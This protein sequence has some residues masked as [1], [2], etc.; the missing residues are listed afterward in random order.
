MDIAG[1]G[2]WAR[3]HGERMWMRG[4]EPRGGAGGGRARGG[5]EADRSSESD[6]GGLLWKGGG[7]ASAP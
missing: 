4:S 1:G 7:P 2:K 6:G 3:G 5:R